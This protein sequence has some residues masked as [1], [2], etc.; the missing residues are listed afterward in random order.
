MNAAGFPHDQLELYVAG[1]LDIEAL[2]SFATHLDECTM[3]SARL[4]IL[5]N[6]VAGLIP[7]SAPPTHVWTRITEAIQ[8]E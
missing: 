3:C 4:P 6:T 7:D 1:A 8:F 5:M 2:D